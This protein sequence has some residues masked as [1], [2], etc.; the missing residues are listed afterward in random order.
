MSALSD[1]LREENHWKT[2]RPKERAN[3]SDNHQNQIQAFT[4]V[5]GFLS[6]F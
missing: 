4:F 2:E 6:V 3:D 5:H 1:S